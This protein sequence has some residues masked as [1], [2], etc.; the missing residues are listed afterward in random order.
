MTINTFHVINI[1]FGPRLW[2]WFLSIKIP[3]TQYNPTTTWFKLYHK[4]TN[5]K[6]IHWLIEL[7]FLQWNYYHSIVTRVSYERGSEVKSTKPYSYLIQMTPNVN[8]FLHVQLIQL[9]CKN[10]CF[11]V[12]LTC[13]SSLTLISGRSFI[14]YTIL[15]LWEEIQTESIHYIHLKLFPFIIKHNGQFCQL[16]IQCLN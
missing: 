12:I 14:Q 16:S 1:H 3:P 7:L 4:C 11:Y 5:F 13:V 2:F 8:T 6:I 9:I 10:E 15:Y